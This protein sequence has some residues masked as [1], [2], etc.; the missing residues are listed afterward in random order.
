MDTT[1]ATTSLSFPASATAEGPQLNAAPSPGST[2]S[3]SAAIRSYSVVVMVA[4]AVSSPLDVSM[5]ATLPSSWGSMTVR[6]VLP[7]F[8]LCPADAGLSSVSG[9]GDVPPPSPR[10]SKHR[11]RA[12]GVCEHVGSHAYRK[13]NK[14]SEA[15]HF[16]I[17]SSSRNEMEEDRHY[18]L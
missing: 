18:G 13:R 11:A 4:G 1:V 7:R 6:I 15:G 5:V 2:T 14:S 9:C 17:S 8:V 3:C 12:C 10:E 16:L